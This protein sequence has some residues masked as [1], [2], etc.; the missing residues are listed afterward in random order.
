MHVTDTTDMT[1]EQTHIHTHTHAHLGPGPVMLGGGALF[2]TVCMQKRTYTTL[3]MPVKSL[4]WELGV[5]DCNLAHAYT[6][7]H[8]CTLDS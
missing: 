4:S 5:H 8:A 2:L 7:A 6:H 3:W 1:L